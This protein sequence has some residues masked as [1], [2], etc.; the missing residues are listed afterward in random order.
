MRVHFILFTLMLAIADA[1]LVN[2]W[3]FN[4]ASGS[5]ATAGTT[6]AD[7]ISGANA[8]IVGTGAS[9]NGTALT[10]PGSIGSSNVGAN[11]IAAYVDLPNGIISSKTN[12]T[13]E[14][15]AAIVASRNQ[16]RLADFGRMTHAGVGSGAASG[17]VTNTSTT[18]PGASPTVS[19]DLNWNVSRSNIISRQR[20]ESRINGAG[21]VLSDT[22][23]A[24]ATGTEYQFV[25]TYTAGA[26]TFPAG[27]QVH[28]YR[29]GSLITTIDLAYPLSSIE[30]VNN[31]LGRSQNTG[32]SPAN[33]RYNEVRIYNH[34]MSAAEISASNTS[35]PN[36]PAPTANADSQSL[37]HLQK[38]LIPVLAND[39]NTTGGSVS[40]VTPPSSGTANVD[41]AGRVLY[42]HATGTPA[43]DSFTYRIS[44]LGGLSGTALV[45]LTFANTLRIPNSSLNVPASPPPLAVQLTT[46]FT[47]LTDPVCL[48]SPPGDT[49][50]LFVCEK[51][52]SLEVYTDVTTNTS[53]PSV[54]LNLASLLT[55]RGEAISTNSEQGLIGLAFHPSYA[56]NRYFYLFY[57]VSKN[58]SVYERVSRFTTSANNPNLADTTSELILLEQLDDEGNHNGGD[59]H[60]GPDGYLYISLGDE[61]DQ[62]DARDN[63]QT[64]TKDFFSAIARIDVDKKPANLNPNTHPAVLRDSGVARYSIPADNPY[65]G[66]TTFNGSAVTPA[67][68]RTEFWAVGLRNPWRMSFDTNGE[69][70]CGDVGGGVFEEI[71]LITKAKNCGW[72]FREGNGDG[73][74]SG[75]AP[76]N[77]NTLYGSLPLY[78]Y[79]HN[80]TSGWDSNFTGNSVTGGIVYRGARFPGWVG[81][82]FFADYVSGNIWS[83]VRN[84]SNPPTVSR[85]AGEGG[86]VA[87]GKDPS[88]GDVLLA[89]YDS[90]V[91]RRLTQE[92][93]TTSFPATLS[94]TGLFADLTDLAPAP[95]LIPYQ[96]NLSFWSDYALKRRW[97]ILPDAA[98]KITWS[99]DGLWTYPSG[100]IWVKHFDLETTRGTPAATKRIETRLLV[101]TPTG[102]YGVSYRWNSAGT[103]ATLVADGGDDFDV[104]IT[105]GGSPYNQRWRIPSR[106]QCS[107]CH[108]PQ[109]GHALSFT[110]RQ[111]NLP[112][113][114]NGFSGN[115]LTLLE[116]GGYFSNSPGSPNLLPRHLRPTETEFSTEARVRSYLVVNCGYCHKSGGTAAPAAWDGSPHLLLNQT[117]LIN[118]SASNNGGST[119]NKLV[120]P[121]NTARSIVLSRI[122]L[123]GGFTRMPPIATNELDQTNIVLLTE[124]INGSLSTRLDYAAWRLARFGSSSSPQGAPDFDADYDGSSNRLEFLTGTLPLSGTSRPAFFPSQPSPGNIRLNFTLPADR[125]ARIETSTNLTT[126]QPWD[127]PGNHAIPRA[128]GSHFLEGPA[129]EI[130]QFFRLDLSEP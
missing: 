99:Q 38:A 42:T 126:W 61:G 24:T 32:D 85:I 31:W 88:N 121:G 77:F 8:I 79:A 36:P 6:M 34:A 7:S 97:T 101:K 41:S 29:N 81:T 102:S 70:W 39:A 128:P 45:N 80:G 28:W 16:Q 92:T 83:L 20:I 116:N 54:F 27:G 117:G 9:F 84:G 72:A 90:D 11:S 51:A 55:S 109:A 108:T 69:L 120:V 47:G 75:S 48:A 46:A 43:T 105:V 65:V 4:N 89:D 15:W 22:S 115:Q 91:I 2:R 113:T 25:M 52:G 5:S 1:A 94:A 35:G 23:I 98:S 86:I 112:G 33:I 44:G 50:R 60:F 30:D 3:S 76:A 95:G 63:S 118:G 49:Q 58:S 53:T 56:T 124:W 10:L 104:P 26:G 103:E 19:D 106:A 40:I 71:N 125:A 129:T 119:L 37:H 100:Q 18:A 67:N 130:K 73:P 59:L 114:I 21:T 122:A 78:P 14:I 57:S 82:Y 12:L 127:I 66:A 62:N 96:V 123:T 17:E 64:I 74:K 107:A 13:V 110:T 68:V 111:I 87:F 93:V